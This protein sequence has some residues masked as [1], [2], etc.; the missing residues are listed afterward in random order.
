MLLIKLIFEK[1][2]VSKRK[3][4]EKLVESLTADLVVIDINIVEILLV[5]QNINQGLSTVIVDFVIGQL[6]LLQ[7][8][9]LG[10]EV[11][12]DLATLGSDLVVR[13]AEDV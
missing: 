3:D 1:V 2:Q 10:D 8:V 13:Q 7:R 9:T 5:L 11:T 12:D 4:L 6:E